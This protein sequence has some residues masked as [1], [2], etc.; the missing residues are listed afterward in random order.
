M[1]NLLR[2]KKVAKRVLWFLAIIIIPAFVLWGAGSLSKRDLPYK[3]IGTID[4][5]NIPVD[6]FVKSTKDVQIGLFLT[7]FNQPQALDGLRKDRKL[8]NRLA[9][10][11]LLVTRSAMKAKISVSNEEVINFITRHPLFVK[12]GVFDD[13]L[14]KY[15]LKNSMGLTPRAFEESVRDFLVNMKYKNAIIE[16]VS[17]SQDELRQ[18]YKNEFEK[19]TVYYVLIDKNDFKEGIEVSEDEITYFYEENK[20]RFKESEKVVLQYIAFP[21][22]EKG[23]KEK[24]LYDLRNAYEKL[25]PRPSDLEK[26]A[27]RLNLVIRETE[28]FS[29]D[30]IVPQI[31]DIK[32]VG[33]I[34]FR[35]R[36]LVDILPVASEEEMGTSYIIRVKERMPPRIKPKDK[37][38]FYIEGIIKNENAL[39]LA[40]DEADK[41]YSIAKSENIGLKKLARIYDL[42]LRNTDLISRFDY[43]EGIGES[44]NIIDSAFRLKLGEISKPL[45]VRKGSALIESLELLAID[46]EKFEKDKENYK[47]KVLSVK[48]IKA[49]ENWFDKAKANSSL[50]VD[51]DRI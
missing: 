11:S 5:R 12:G 48:K 35:L 44:Y 13:R 2:R 8:L 29:Q 34:S 32:H 50:N 10:E 26:T 45:K 31:G 46:E 9:W 22:K 18:S 27:K 25:R 3:Y 42:N 39:G 16:N 36:P 19:A 17:I 28:P 14:Y 41:L 24:A 6:T 4:G 47:N 33:I 15:I 21:H 37:V 20:D 40:K 38:A 51:L 7:Y 1:L 49:L 23:T 43:V 30:E